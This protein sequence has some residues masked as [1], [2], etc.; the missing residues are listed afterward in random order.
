MDERIVY[1]DDAYGWMILKDVRVD[2]MM[3][4]WATKWCLL[5][6]LWQMKRIKCLV[7]ELLFAIRLESDDDRD[8]SNLFI[9]LGVN[10]FVFERKTRFRL[11]HFIF[12]ELAHMS[13]YY[14]VCISL[15]NGEMEGRGRRRRVKCV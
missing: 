1:S 13:P 7:E 10:M 9:A 3:C 12:Y 6:S 8:F 11:S 2:G 14:C 5:F 4:E 15:M